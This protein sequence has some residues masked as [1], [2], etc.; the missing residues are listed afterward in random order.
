MAHQLAAHDRGRSLQLVRDLPDA[1]TV[2]V[3]VKDV[4]PLHRRQRAEFEV[5]HLGNT[6][7]SDYVSG[8]LPEVMLND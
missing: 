6:L 4:S 8:R 5:P 1:E 7:R 2:E 3:H